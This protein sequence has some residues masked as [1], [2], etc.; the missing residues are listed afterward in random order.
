MNARIKIVT[1]IA[2]SFVGLLA[3]STHAQPS[4]TAVLRWAAVVAH[5][6]PMTPNPRSYRLF[7]TTSEITLAI[8]LFNESNAPVT[9]ERTVFTEAA[10]FEVT[11][12]QTMSVV[13]QWMTA[14]RRSGESI[15]QELAPQEEIRLESGRGFEWRV[16]LRS[17]SGESF[18]AGDYELAIDLSRA[19]TSVTTADGTK[20]A[21]QFVPRN[22][23]HVS[24]APA[25]TPAEQAAMY[26][27]MAE[28]A[29]AEQR[30]EQAVGLFNRALQAT[31][32]DPDSLAGLG[33]AYLRLG[34]YRDAVSAF[35]QAL[36]LLGNVRSGVPTLLALA[37]VGIGDE[38]SATAI[39]RRA[40]KSAADV[41][42]DIL[43]FR[44]QVRR[45]PPR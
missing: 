21:G 31:P 14:I 1:L 22:T 12:T 32:T 35:T 4:P 30:P 41:N 18:P 33:N 37:Y 8:T 44:E 43:N 38:A 40:G 17:E 36:P 34:R 29:L 19:L 13:P 9:I 27:G 11:G 28:Q 20:W 10:R 24:L 45:N 16:I 5:G 26:R 6:Q 39:L 42:R 15:P 3:R 7:G 25:S 23:Y 2:A